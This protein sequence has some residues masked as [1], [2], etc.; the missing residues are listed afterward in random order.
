MAET[1]GPGD[2]LVHD[3]LATPS[4]YGLAIER[5]YDRVVDGMEVP[6]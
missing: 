4:L 5:A 3:L 6:A 1:Y 2:A